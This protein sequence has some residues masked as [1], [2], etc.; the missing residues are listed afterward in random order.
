MRG[1]L[2]WD[3]CTCTYVRMC[4]CSQLGRSYKRGGLS[5]GG[6]SKEVLLYCGRR[7]NWISEVLISEVS[8]YCLYTYV[9]LVHSLLYGSTH[10]PSYVIQFT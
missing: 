5:R 4:I 7:G 3:I 6:L 2:V 8:L 9:A 10:T 1:N